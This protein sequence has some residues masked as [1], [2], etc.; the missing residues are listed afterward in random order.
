MKQ[1]SDDAIE[2]FFQSLYSDADT[3]YCDF[4]IDVLAGHK[5]SV[6]V[7]VSRMYR[8]ADD[9]YGDPSPPISV[10]VLEISQFFETKDVNEDRYHTDGCKTCDY[11]S[12]YQMNFSI[13]DDHK[14]WDAEAC[15]AA[16]KFFESKDDDVNS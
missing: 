9:T 5:D 2:A 4:E 8:Y 1:H 11:G 10:A 16:L 7:K 3:K 12:N 15:T 13:K 6:R 14:P